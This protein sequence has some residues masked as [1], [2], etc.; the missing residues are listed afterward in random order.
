MVKTSK[1]L[2]KK[3]NRQNN[4]TKKIRYKL[5]GNELILRKDC[6]IGLKPFEK[7]YQ[8][9]FKT[10]KL[11]N[12]STH[13]FTKL[14]LSKFAPS[15]IK[16]QNDYYSYINYKWLENVALEKQQKYIVQ[17]DDFRLTQDK[18]YHHLHDIIIDYIK[19]N[20]TKLAKIMKNFYDSVINMNLP[21]VSKS[22]CKHEVGVINDFIKGGNPWKLLAYINRT[23]MYNYLAPLVFMISP[24]DKHSSIFRGYVN[25]HQFILLDL[26][27]YYDDGREVEYKKK[28]R[29]KFK[30]FC[31]DLFNLCLGKGHGYNTDDVYDVEVQIFNVLGCQAITKNDKSYNRV[32]KKEALEKYNFDWEEFTKH[33]GFKKPPDFFITSSLNYLKCGTD[34]YLKNW[35][36]EKWTTYWVYMYLQIICRITRNWE[37]LYYNFFGKF[38]RGQ[39]AINQTDAVSSSLYMSIPFNSFLSQKYVEKYSDPAKIEYVKILCNDL[40]LV[41]HRIMTNNTWLSPSTKKYAL[42]KLS[43]LKFSV[44][45]PETVR[46]DPMLDY[47]DCLYNNMLLISR[48]RIDRFI[49]LEGKQ[50]IDLPFVDFSQ[51]PVK[52]TGNQPYIVNASYT[53][54]KNEIYINLG[55]IQKPFVDLD[56]RGIEYNLAHLGFTISHEMSHGFDDWGSQYD[57][58]GNLNDWWTLEDKKKFKEIQKN[59]IKQ[60]EEFAAR[61]GIK[62]DASIGIGEDLADI[63]GMAICDKYLKDYQDNNNDLIPIRYDSYEIF[64]IYFAFQ[65]KQKVSKKALTAQLKT[66]PHPLDKYR[67]NVPLSRSLIFRSI[68]DVKKGD[69]MWWHN[70]HTIWDK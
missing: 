42:Y 32:T 43:K 47:N 45:Y 40:K 46:E 11:Y 65:Q 22:L 58:D 62:F 68:Y 31:K 70:T 15:K 64:Y 33:L 8:K 3:T 25:P 67:C 38:E 60:Y 56:E 27:V 52:L 51:Y 50:V 20:D 14:L 5:T 19:N 10:N 9:E 1:N 16:P 2:S 69:G 63:S 59:V 37:K 21:N 49:E 36:S 34:L 41:F 17:V 7:K 28:Y 39:Q 26:D 23:N 13:K 24:D 35:N 29:N 6:P 53:P 12:L 54:S 48:W 55:Y 18:V 30:K 61:D 57:A 4:K 66:N 44:G